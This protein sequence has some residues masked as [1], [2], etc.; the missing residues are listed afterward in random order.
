MKNVLLFLTCAA[1]LFELSTQKESLNLYKP[2]N[3]P[4][5][6]EAYKKVNGTLISEK[7]KVTKPIFKNHTECPVGY[8]NSCF[9]SLAGKSFCTCIMMNLQIFK[10]TNKTTGCPKGYSFHCGRIRRGCIISFGCECRKKTS[11]RYPP[12]LREKLKENIKSSEQNK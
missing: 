3:L 4:N 12:Y 6:K 5:M 8:R 1:L 9:T 7:P 2:K 11:I 10:P